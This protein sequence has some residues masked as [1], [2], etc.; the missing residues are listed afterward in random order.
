MTNHRFTGLDKNMTLRVISRELGEKLIAG[1]SG[2]N[3]GSSIVEAGQDTAHVGT[4]TAV[5]GGSF[6]VQKDRA[7]YADNDDVTR[8]RFKRRGMTKIK[9]QLRRIRWILGNLFAYVAELRSPTLSRDEK[10]IMLKRFRRWDPDELSIHRRQKLEAEIFQTHKIQAKLVK[11]QIIDVLTRLG[12]NYSITKNERRYIKARVKIAHVDVSPYAYV[13]HISRVPYGVRMTDMAKDEV[14]TELAATLGKKIRHDLDLNGL[15]Y[16]VEVGSTMSIPHFVEFGDERFPMPKNQP[17]LAFFAGLSTNGTAV[18]R[19]LAAAPHIIIAGETGGGKSNIEN[20]IACTLISR[21]DANRLRLVF[22]DLKGGVEFSH[23]EDLPHLWKDE[24]MIT[25]SGEDE[26]KTEKH[27]KCDGIIER[28]SDVMG[29]LYL[30]DRECNRRLA[31]L[32]ASKKKN[33]H[34]F[35]RGKHAQNMLPYIVVFFDEWAVTKSQVPGAETRLSTIA[36]LSRAA[37]IHFML[38]T[39]YPKAEILNTAISVNFPWRFAFNMQSGASMSVLGN[40]DAFGLSPSGR[41]VLKTNE[42]SIQVQ[43][44]RITE[45]MIS[46]TVATAKKEK[47][48]ETRSAGV[49]EKDILTWAIDNAGGKLSRDQLFNQFKEKIG[50]YALRDLL[51]SMENQVFDVHG[52]LYRVLPGGPRTPR[53]MDLLDEIERGV[54]GENSSGILYPVNP[55]EQPTTDLE[56]ERETEDQQ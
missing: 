19:N 27:F 48:E 28:P 24:G 54:L 40:W 56:D 22:F 42:G 14:S 5:S 36:N 23:F 9:R 52:S 11:E 12:F 37:G 7:P 49:D 26:E 33:I 30:L 16:T 46:A 38:S 21:N 25:T 45:R 55:E 4:D 1:T 31:V 3:S 35:N 44:P 8:V 41:A 10:M 13:F 15:R 53:R 43:T 18:F 47:V 2:A 6:E 50:N 39:Q 29:A 34:E 51:K 17:P 32:K 20:A